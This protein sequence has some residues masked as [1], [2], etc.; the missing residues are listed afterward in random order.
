MSRTPK[1]SPIVATYLY[2]GK[3][4]YDNIE[5][6]DIA[7]TPKTVTITT[8]GGDIDIPIPNLSDNLQFGVHPTAKDGDVTTLIK[9][10]THKHEFRWATLYVD[11]ST[12]AQ[13]YVV[14]KVIAHAVYAGN[15]QDSI[16]PGDNIESN[17]SFNVLDY[18]YF[19][20]KSRTPQIEIDKI[21]GTLKIDGKDYTN[22]I[23][24]LIA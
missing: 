23:F 15:D 2:D 19:V 12:K 7:Y 17:Y 20:G 16:K 21:T 6:T 14:N 10:G 18:Q 5:F 8:A 4:L 13:K 11:P 22:D 9:P 3:R 1:S 24:K